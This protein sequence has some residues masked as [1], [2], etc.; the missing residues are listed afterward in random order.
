MRILKTNDWFQN[1]DCPLALERRAPQERFG[2]YSHEFCEI[3]II[4]AG[5]ALHVTS[6]ESRPVAAGDVFVVGGSEVHEYREMEDLRLVN[7]LFRPE[8]LQMEL[9]D[10][11][12]LPGYLALF[13]VDSSGCKGQPENMTL[14][15]APK[16]LIIALSHVERLGH[17]LEARN[18]GFKFMVQTYFMQLV[19]YL[20]RVCSQ[21]RTRDADVRAVASVDK[22][23]SHLDAHFDQPIN[24]DD[25]ARLSHMSKRSFLRAFQAAT[26]STPIAYLVSLRLTRAAAMLLRQ[27]ESV[28]SVAFKVGFNDSNY[29]AR[30]FHAMFEVPP[31]EYR[32]QRAP[33]KA[34]SS[35]RFG[36]VAQPSRFRRET[37]KTAQLQGMVSFFDPARR[38]RLGPVMNEMRVG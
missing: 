36:L 15:L 20:S 7:I 12:I 27:E 16:E 4:L 33:M 32:N 11:P 28:T 26:G 6:H 35:V 25:L 30:R 10:L 19:C 37:Q 17:E 5:R 8:K 23:I 1:D 24:L 21:S 2:P 34:T 31:S 22:A 3:V 9:L 38:V 13:A 14:R 18:P 29:F